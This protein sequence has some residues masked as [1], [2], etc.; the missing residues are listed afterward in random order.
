VNIALIENH[1]PVLGCTFRY[2]IKPMSAAKG[3]ARSGAKG[4]MTPSQSMSRLRPPVRP[5]SLA[6]ARTGEPVLMPI[7]QTLANTLCRCRRQCR[8]LSA[9]WPDVG[10]GHG[11]RPGCCG[12]GWRQRRYA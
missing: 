6:V 9:P 4:T 11:S 8:P 3:S 5:A 10:M 7:S 12:A 1:R 2:R